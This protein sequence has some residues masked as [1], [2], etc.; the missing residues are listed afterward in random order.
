MV[1]DESAYERVKGL[2]WEFVT[3]YRILAMSEIVETLRA[4]I[5]DAPAAGG[6]V[7]GTVRQSGSQ[8]SLEMASAQ[9][10][11]PRL[12]G[13]QL[14]EI[15]FV[16]VKTNDLV[17]EPCQPLL[18]LANFCMAI[19]RGEADYRQTLFMQGQDTLVR[20]GT[21]D[22]QQAQTGAGAVLDVPMGGD[23]KFIGVSS[24]GLSEQR[25]ALQN[26]KARPTSTRSRHSMPATGSKP[27]VARRCAFACRRGQPRWPACISR[28][29]RP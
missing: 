23:A 9:F 19:Y 2:R 1:L 24:S 4:T 3:R 13:T 16:F 12:G 5:H 8:G 7:V 26:D 29:P 20:I 11:A 18:G 6:Y 14:T 15:P 27:R 25:Q 22:E 17:P 28:R 21:S 10:I